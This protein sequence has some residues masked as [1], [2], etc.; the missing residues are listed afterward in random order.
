MT[1][2]HINNNY[3]LTAPALNSFESAFICN[4]SA[5]NSCLR[6]TSKETNFLSVMMSKRHSLS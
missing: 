4:T 5:F 1:V 6:N 2:V 3:I